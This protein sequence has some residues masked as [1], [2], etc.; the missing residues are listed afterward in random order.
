MVLEVGMPR[1]VNCCVSSKWIIHRYHAYIPMSDGYCSGSLAFDRYKVQTIIIKQSK[2]ETDLNNTWRFSPY[3]TE[4]VSLIC[5][6][7]RRMFGGITV[8]ENW[9]KRYHKELMQLYGGSDT[10]SSVRISWLNWIGHVSRMDSKRKAFNNNPQ[11]GQLRGRPR[12]MVELHT[13]RY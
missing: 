11:G 8:N 2:G 12:K 7:L 9:G 3:F 4:N 5:C 13:N 6:G 1:V 10:L